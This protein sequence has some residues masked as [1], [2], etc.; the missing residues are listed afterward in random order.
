MLNLSRKF[1]AKTITPKPQIFSIA[2]STARSFLFVFSVWTE[3][4]FLYVKPVRK[5]LQN[6]AVVCLK[7]IR[8][9]GFILVLNVLFFL[10]T[11]TVDIFC[12]SSL[13]L[14]FLFFFILLWRVGLPRRVRAHDVCLC[15]CL[16][17][18]FLSLTIPSHSRLFSLLVSS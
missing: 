11:F 1:F 5:M 16:L 14:T 13:S 8:F 15:S 2:S 7:T 12:S 9:V 10:D 4:G 3:N 17:C 6:K 18:Y